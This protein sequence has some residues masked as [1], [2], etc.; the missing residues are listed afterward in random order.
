[1][2][3]FATPYNPFSI[4]VGDSLIEP[5]PST[6]ILGM[7]VDSS[8]T[9]EGHISAVVKRCYATM[10]GLVKLSRSLPEKVKKMIV[11]ALVFPHLTYCMTVW[12]GCDKTQRH[13]LQKVLNHCAQIVK[14]ARRSAHVTPLMRELEWPNIDNLIAERD[15]GITHWLLTNQHAPLSLRELVVSRES[16]SLRDTRATA[17]G[18]LQLPR[19][20]TE[21][22]RR[23]FKC[24]AAAQWNR[25]PTTVK[26]AKFS[27]S[28]RRLA[29]KWLMETGQT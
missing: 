27:I 25:A 11:E 8:L 2:T 23:F 12:S 26:A 14:G 9:F 15:I 28:C 5:S 17:A 24:R 6:K 16:V 13:R 29:R 22:A 20:R 3:F 7:I 18:Q 21:Q 10:G 19:V 4:T 1:M